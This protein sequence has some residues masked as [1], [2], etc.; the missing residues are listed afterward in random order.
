LTK[1]PNAVGSDR[2]AH[3]NRNHRDA[4]PQGGFDLDADEV[5]GIIP[6]LFHQLRPLRADHRQQ[7]VRLLH[8]GTNVGN[9]IRPGRNGIDVHEDMTHTIVLLQPAMHAP[10]QPGSQLVEVIAP[11]GKEDFEA[12]H[13]LPDS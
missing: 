8:P 6:P 3:E 2:A 11:V 12:R 7:D 13:E 9:K 4:P 5:P 1:S 10:D